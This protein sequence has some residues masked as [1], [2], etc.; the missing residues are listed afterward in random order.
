MADFHL[1]D[2][3]LQFTLFQGMSKGDLEL[4]VA[5]TRLGFHKYAPGETIAADG[6]VCNR[7]LFLTDGHIHIHTTSSNHAFTVTEVGHSPEMFQAESIFG[8]SQ[9]FTHTY[10]ALTPCSVLS[11]SKDEVY[12]IF[13]TFTIFRINLVNL[14]STRLQK[15]HTRTWR[16]TSPTLR[17]QTINFFESHCLYPAGEKH[18]KIKMQ[19]LADELG[20]KRLYVSQ[21]LKTLQDEGLLTL[22]RGAIHIQALER[23]LM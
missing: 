19:Q 10:Q 20:T 4:I 14:L 6:D 3:L 9:R 17:Q 21:T 12:R 7:L 22:S 1:Y 11:I 13:E 15:Q 8:L 2:K 5:H 23:L 18:L 16:K